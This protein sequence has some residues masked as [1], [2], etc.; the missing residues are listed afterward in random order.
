M[1]TTFAALAL[2][3][4]LFVGSAPASAQ[5]AREVGSA[6]AGK[7]LDGFSEQDRREIDKWF[8][9]ARDVLTDSTENTKGHKFKKTPPG[10]AK[11]DHLP[12]GLAKRDTLP[13][14]L[15]GRGLPQDLEG[16]LSRLPK[17]Y[18]RSQ[19]GDDVVLIEEATGILIDIIRGVAKG[20]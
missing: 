4:A 17:G 16:R 19:V 15:Q 11:R 5:T 18:K 10:L 14:G 6:I 20:R 7:A 9:V 13:P 3:P 12:P 8:R 1:K 2:V